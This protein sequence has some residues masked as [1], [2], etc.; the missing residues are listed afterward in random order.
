MLP[1]VATIVVL[2]I[3]S[4]DATAIKLNAPASIGKPFHPDG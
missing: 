2:A 4:R 3:I 1:Y